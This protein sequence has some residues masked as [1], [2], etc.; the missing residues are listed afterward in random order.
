MKRIARLRL[1]AFKAQQ[2]R[3]FYCTSRM[4]VKSPSELESG[5]I[6]RPA[7]LLQCTAEHLVAR[8]WGGKEDVSN[9]VAA[10]W[11]CNQTRHRRKKELSAAEFKLLVQ[12]HL[13]LR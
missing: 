7:R 13:A 6:N 2:G 9:I 11:R 10:C 12:K 5:A 3:C 1:D 8:Q 4:W